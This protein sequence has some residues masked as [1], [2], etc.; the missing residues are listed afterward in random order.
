TQPPRRTELAV[1]THCPYCAYQCGVRMG[2]PDEVVG[3]PHFPV[4]NGELCVKGWTATALLRH[5]RR[6]TTPLVRDR[7]SDDFRAV[8]WD[9]AL[10]RVAAAVTR[11]REEFGPDANGVFGSGALTNES[12]YLLGKFARVALGTANVDYNGRYCMSSAAA[13]ANRAFGLD[14]GLPFPVS[15][16]ADAGVV[17]LVGSNCADTLPPIMRWFDRQRAN[18]GRL[19]VID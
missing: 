11:A 17:V 18:G 10:D 14:R 8:D 4:N 7:R 12:A 1:R 16:I 6:L 9:E 15:D 13:G 19:V 2:D 3:D 5:P